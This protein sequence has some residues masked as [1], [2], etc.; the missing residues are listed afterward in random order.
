MFSLLQE[1]SG[2]LLNALLKR[3][4]SGEQSV[5]DSVPIATAAPDA[6]KLDAVTPEPE[7]LDTVAPN[8]AAPSPPQPLSLA[9]ESQHSPSSLG[10]GD[11]LEDELRSKLSQPVSRANSKDSSSSEDECKNQP[12]DKQTDRENDRLREKM[13]PKDTERGRQRPSDRLRDR[14]S[15][16]ESE[17]ASETVEQMNGQEMKRSERL[18]KSASVREEG[19]VRERRSGSLEVTVGNQEQKR[20]DKKEQ[21]RQIKR[22]NKR[23]VEKETEQRRGARRSGSSASSPANTPSSQEGVLSDNQVRRSEGANALVLIP[24]LTFCFCA[25]VLGNHC[26][27][28]CLLIYLFF[29][30]QYLSITLHLQ[31]IKLLAFVVQ[32]K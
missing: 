13:R 16:K 12:V 7:D 3:G 29:I 11:P 26:P 9:Q 23:D 8:S 19:R 25:A 15:S 1:N 17:G 5:P 10:P 27:S 28:V 18:I 30:C 20:G 14:T 6:F 22:Q 2:F 24:P 4:L 32:L 21:N 31:V